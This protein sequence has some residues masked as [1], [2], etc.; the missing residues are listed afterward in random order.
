MDKRELFFLP[1]VLLYFSGH[2]R[3]LCYLSSEVWWVNIPVQCL[4][5]ISLPKPLRVVIYKERFY[6]KIN[7]WQ[8]EPQSKY[9]RTGAMRTLLE[10]RCSYWATSEVSELIFTKMWENLITIDKSFQYISVVFLQNLLLQ[11]CLILA[12]NWSGYLWGEF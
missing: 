5:C 1:Y 11:N 12:I 3:D 8:N 10:T 2:L 9:L 6:F 7:F 4:I